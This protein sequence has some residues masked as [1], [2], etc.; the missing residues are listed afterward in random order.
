MGEL[1]PR[2]GQLWNRQ[3]HLQ[4]QTKKTL[5]VILSPFIIFDTLHSLAFLVLSSSLI[6]PFLITYYYFPFLGSLRGRHY[7][8]C[9]AKDRGVKHFVTWGRE[10]KSLL[11]NF[12][13]IYIHTYIYIYIRLSI[14]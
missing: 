2:M 14:S 9:S 4:E 8:K 1:Q 6:V 5:R 12:Y 13:T 11:R 7:V 10:R 3:T